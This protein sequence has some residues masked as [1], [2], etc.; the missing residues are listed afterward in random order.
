MRKLKL[1]LSETK[2]LGDE[3]IWTDDQ[4]NESSLVYAYNWYRAAL[5]PKVARL[6]LVDYMQY[7]KQYSQDDI[8]VLDY[9]EDWRFEATNLPALGRMIMRGLKPTERQQERLDTEIPLLLVRG[10]ERRD[11]TRESARRLKVKVAPPVPKDPAGDAM[12]MIEIA[13]D[14]GTAV[15]ATGILKLHQPRPAD[16]KSDTERMM[17]LVEEVQHALDRTDDQCV[18]AYRSYTKKQLRDTL[19]R[20]AGVL[21]AINLYCSANIKPPKVRKARPK[22]PEKLVAKLRYLDRFDE[23]GLVSIDPKDIIGATEVLLYH[24][25]RRYVY[26]YVAPL[27]SKLSVRRSVIDGYDPKLS[28]R[29]KLRLPEDVLKRLMSGGIKSVAKTFDSIK[30]KPAEVNGVVNSQ[31][32]IL[33]AGK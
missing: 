12:A 1:P 32:L 20:Y 21:Q 31:I 11:A 17:R 8:D 18:E 9:V 6:V 13:L 16:L 5:E 19:A 15:D 3:P 29:K 24:P 23:L 27:G 25:A 4:T 33:R 10:Q 7:T 22:T 14:A 26:R 28:F 30:T 2:Y